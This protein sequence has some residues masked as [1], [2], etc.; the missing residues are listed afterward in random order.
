MN[1]KAVTSYTHCF[2]H[3]LFFLMNAL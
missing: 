1:V 2:N 3:Y